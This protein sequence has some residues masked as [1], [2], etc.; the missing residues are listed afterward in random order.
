MRCWGRPVLLIRSATAAWMISLLSASAC[1]LWQ[2]TIGGP[3]SVCHSA[4]CRRCPYPPRCGLMSSMEP[5]VE[6][7]CETACEADDD[8]DCC[9]EGGDSAPDASSS[10]RTPRPSVHGPEGKRVF[11][12]GCS[13]WCAPSTPTGAQ[14]L[15]KSTCGGLGHTNGACA[16]PRPC[17]SGKRTWCRTRAGKLGADSASVLNHAPRVARAAAR[18][19]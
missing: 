7:V 18:V 15:R 8:T 13:G 4:P 3:A 6:D 10:W 5:V 9:E 16:L 14:E 11:A 19:L 12:F 2:A 17:T 1:A